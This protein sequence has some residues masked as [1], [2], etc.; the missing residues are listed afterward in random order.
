MA[1]PAMLPTPTR[2]AVL[3][4]NAWNELMA[5]PSVCL[6][7]PSVRSRSISG[8]ILTWTKRVAKVK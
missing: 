5:C 8:S 3:T 1:T 7:M 4:Q 2:E 6:P